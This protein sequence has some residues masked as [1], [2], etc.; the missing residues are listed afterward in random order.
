M[1]FTS[2]F[3]I[4]YGF[5]ILYN[6]EQS[7]STSLKE[8]KIYKKTIKITKNIRVLPMYFIGKGDSVKKRGENTIVVRK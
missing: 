2:L 5:M 6:C 8:S 4:R 1:F 7:V 3:V